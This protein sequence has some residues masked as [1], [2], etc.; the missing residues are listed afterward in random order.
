[1]RGG[2]ADREVQLKAEFHHGIGFVDL[3]VGEAPAT[4]FEKGLPGSLHNGLVLLVATGDVQQTENH[5]ARVG[6]QKAVEVTAHPVALDQAGNIGPG[7]RWKFGLGRNRRW[8]SLGPALERQ[9]H[10]SV[11]I[12]AEILRFANAAGNWLMSNWFLEPTFE[13]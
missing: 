12:I 10:R 13:S 9:S 6:A 5:T 1:S 4:Q 3:R 7:Q 2:P 11:R 8:R